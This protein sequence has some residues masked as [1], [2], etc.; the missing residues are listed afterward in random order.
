MNFAPSLGYGIK[1]NNP[2]TGIEVHTNSGNSYSLIKWAGLESTPNFVAIDFDFEWYDS[3]H[4]FYFG[5]ATGLDLGSMLSSNTSFKLGIYNNY[6]N[7]FCKVGA[8]GLIARMNATE[9]VRYRKSDYG[10][11]Y[12]IDS[13]TF[14][15]IGYNF[16]IGLDLHPTK[17]PFFIR[18][19][20]DHE[21]YNPDFE[22]K[23]SKFTDY[24][25]SKDWYGD[26]DFH[27]RAFSISIGW[28]FRRKNII[29]EDTPEDKNSQENVRQISFNYVD[30]PLITDSNL[31]L[32]VSDA[33]TEK[34]VRVI[35]KPFFTNEE[36]LDKIE[37]TLM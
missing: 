31:L 23:T 29:K 16:G 30:T 18:L 28:Q 2:S 27:N 13:I 11:Y 5:I 10:D 8:S 37:D 32:M 17:G 22:I 14:Y 3:E 19:S 25:E 35:G 20:Y 26:H 1:F 34:G 36:K 4:P 7:L 33:L 24:I 12:Q 15:G 6:I 21:I 9:N